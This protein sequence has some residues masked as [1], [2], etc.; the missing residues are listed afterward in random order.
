MGRVESKMAFVT[1]GAQGLGR[2]SA[3]LMAK[4]GAKVTVAD[5]NEAGAKKVADEINAAYPGKGFAVALDVTSESQWQSALDEA[6]SAMGG[7]NVLVNNAG[8]GGGSTVE[9]TDFAT[10]KKVQEVDSDSVFLGCKYA[11]RHMVPHA[12][13][14]IINVSSIAGLIAGHNMAAYNAA[15]A[16]VWLLSKSVALHCAKRGYNIR[17]NSVHPTFI[18]TPIL[19]GMTGAMSKDELKR[20][21]AKQVPLGVVGEPDDVAY[22][23]LFLA[24]DESK[25]ITGSE[26]KIDGGISAM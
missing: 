5:I 11:I 26:I 6:V 13:G 23:V 12:P 20:K 18:D 25:F 15:K 3:L 24:S 22:A 1:G 7:L 2:A 4:E 10:W 21:L 16:A 8:I 19:D 17:S 9:D 14:S